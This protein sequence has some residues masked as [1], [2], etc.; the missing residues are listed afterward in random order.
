MLARGG[1]PNEHRL[2]PHADGAQQR[3]GDQL[4][5]RAENADQDRDENRADNVEAERR[6][7]LAGPD[8]EREGERRDEEHARHHAPGALAQ[9]AR[10]IE[11]RAREDE[12]E[13]Q[14]Q[15]RQPVGLVV[16][17]EAPEDRLGVE[18]VG[19]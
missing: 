1:V 18:E 10:R 17:E 3:P 13:Q 14:D 5:A 8:G 4:V 2:A 19:T 12:H 9:L 7:V 15:E 11:A 16:P 6:E